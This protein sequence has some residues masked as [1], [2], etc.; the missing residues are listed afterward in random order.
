MNL[1]ISAL[2]VAACCVAPA[3]AAEPSKFIESQSQ[4]TQELMQFDTNKDGVV[5]LVE[6]ANAKLAE[7]TNADADKDG[8]L[9]WEEFKKQRQAKRD[10]RVAKMFALADKNADKLLT[11][12]EFAQ[13]FA[14]SD[15]VNNAAITRAN[16]AFAILDSNSNAVLDSAEFGV[17][18]ADTETMPALIWQFAGMDVNGDAKL[19]ADEYAVKVTT[20]PKAPKLPKPTLPFSGKK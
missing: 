14:V 4:L 13:V 9:T 1:S 16:T 18:F 12:E 11:S 8:F 5:T 7:F 19:A 15:E 6:K 20:L 2:L 17:L 10:E 3:M